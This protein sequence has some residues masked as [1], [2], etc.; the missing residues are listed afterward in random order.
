MK[1]LRFALL[2]VLWLLPLWLSAAPGAVRNGAVS[3]ELVAPQ[4]SIQPGQIFRVALKL[5]H[6]EYWHSYWINPVTGN[7]YEHTVLLFVDITPP[8][9]L[10]AGTPVTLRA[11]AEWLMCEDVCVPG[12]ADLELTLDV[13]PD[14]PA[15]NMSIGRLFNNAVADLP[16]PLEGWTASATR[17]DHVIIFKLTPTAK[18][19][20]HHPAELH[21]FDTAGV[22]DY[23]A[24]QQL[25]EENG[26]LVLALPIA[27]DAPE[28]ATRLAGVLV[29]ANGWGG[30]IPSHGATFDVAITDSSQQSAVS[31]QPL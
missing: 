22:I 21:L 1:L 4:L 8:A 18:S 10:P 17:K 16:K 15:A 31:S 29:S 12:A 25:T 26:T 6:K 5:D 9:T 19:P 11:K 24:P 14:E 28:N 7:G 27:K 3:A 13:S 2:S 23:A 20:G 30:L